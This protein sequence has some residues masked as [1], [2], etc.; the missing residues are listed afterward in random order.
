MSDPSAREQWLAEVHRLSKRHLSRY[1][2]TEGAVG[3]DAQGA[4]ILIL[5]TTGRKSGEKRSTPLIFGEDRDRHVVVASLGGYP[6]HPH[7]YL[8]LLA[9]PEAEVQVKA[10]RFG[11]RAYTASGDERS[12]LWTL[13]TS[14]WPSYDD[15]QGRTSREI[16]V[17]VLERMSS[18]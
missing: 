5:T 18:D 14:I 11:A 16:P 15:Y 6:T 17:V 7:W 13:M 8:N 2:E 1:L 10:E 4:P 9:N 12:R 3:A